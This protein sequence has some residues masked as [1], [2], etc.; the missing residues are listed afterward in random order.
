MTIR[1]KLNIMLVLILLVGVTLTVTIGYI[2]F[3]SSKAGGNYSVAAKIMAETFEFSIVS[4]DYLLDHSDRSLYQMQQKQKKLNSLLVQAEGMKEEYPDSVDRLLTQY[5]RIGELLQRLQFFHQAALKTPAVTEAI[6]KTSGKTEELARLLSVSVFDIAAQARQLEESYDE[7]KSQ[8]FRAVQQV[9]LFSF[10]LLFILSGL[11]VLLFKGSVLARLQRLQQ[12]AGQLADNQLGLQIDETGSDELT[13]LSRSFNRMSTSLQLSHDELRLKSRMLEE[14][15]LLRRAA[16][17]RLEGMNLELERQV[18]ERT[19]SLEETLELFNLFMH[20]SPIFT[21]IKEVTPTGSQVLQASE[22][23]V[24]M[25]GIPGSQMRGKT[26][27]ELFAPEFADRIVA[28]DQRVVANNTVLSLEE[29][30]NGRRYL[31]FKFPIQR[32]EKRLLAGYS[33]DITDQ[34]LAE[35][36]LREM[37]ARFLQNEKMASIGQLSAGIAHEINNPMGFVSGNFEV[38]VKYVNKFDEY[39]SLLEQ[40]VQ[41]ENNSRHHEL[42]VATRA[43]LKLDYVQRDIRQLLAESSEGLDRVKRI[44]RDLKVFAHTDIGQS[45]PTD[46]NQCL[47]RTI[48]MVWNEI[49]YV[50]ELVRDYGVLPK[51]NCNS[52]QVSQVFMNLLVNAVHAIADLGPE[53]LGKLVVKTWADS[54]ACYVAISDSGCGMTE[55]LQRRI[56]EPFYTTKEVGKGTGLGLSISYELIKKHGGELTVHSVLGKGSTFTIRLPLEAKNMNAEQEEQGHD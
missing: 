40:L 12:G 51:V 30:L 29:E 55:E 6:E 5:K 53:Q 22:N 31:T 2:G 9:S 28:D 54:S 50:A 13:T 27:H 19:R 48:N 3:L 43:K 39:I 17:Q 11:S 23:F 8:L 41:E 10:L 46:L 42:V 15:V 37:Q 25:I 34:K 7:R 14:E 1:R 56:F 33:I 44:V 21:F 47:E 36:E 26:M 24:E 32:G 45:D 16:Q 18:A 20:H 35:A 49:K 52:Q 38:L 4:Q